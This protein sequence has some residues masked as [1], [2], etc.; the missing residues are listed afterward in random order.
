MTAKKISDNEVE[1]TNIS[2]TKTVYTMEQL[3]EKKAKYQT[4]LDE[5]N[6]WLDLL[7]E[8]QVEDK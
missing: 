1:V 7:S 4:A 8:H 3:L 5:V 2:T 6:S